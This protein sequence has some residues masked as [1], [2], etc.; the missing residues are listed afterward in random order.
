MAASPFAVA[1]KKRANAWKKASKAAPRTGGNRGPV[2]IPDGQYQAV[3]SAECG[4]SEKGESAGTPWVKITAT[5]NDGEQEGKE[6]NNFYFL[7]G[8]MP[9]D[10]DDAMPT[11]EERLAGDLKQILPDVEVE[12]TDATQIEA[13]VEEINTRSPVMRIGVKNRTGKDG[14]KSAGKRF[15]DIYFNEL[16]SSGESNAEEGSAQEEGEGEEEV[17]EESEEED[18]SELVEEEGEEAP[19]VGDPVMYKPQG[20]AKAR[21]FAVMTVNQG[22]RTVTLSDGKK[23]YSNV[24]WDKIER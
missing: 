22:K 3:I 8:K 16:L 24:S 2:D 18:D 17:T 20:A 23:K 1:M 19:A 9:S 21:E 11:N 10:A 5:V 12:G 15:Q 14:T 13:F 4:V 6:P 7:D